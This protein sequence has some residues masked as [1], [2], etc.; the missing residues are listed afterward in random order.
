MSTIHLASRVL[1]LKEIP[2]P[3]RGEGRTGGTF[4]GGEPVLGLGYERCIALLS[5]S[6]VTSASEAGRSTLLAAK[7]SACG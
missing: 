2:Y 1:L 4:H 6:S 5:K 3:E 7:S